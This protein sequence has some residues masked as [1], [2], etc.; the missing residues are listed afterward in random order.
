MAKKTVPVKYTDRD[1]ESIKQSLI[2]HAKRYYPET[3]KDFSEASFGSLMLDT[4]SYVGDVLSFYV[5][6]SV[7]ESFI[8]SAIEY[9][10][11]VKLA[12]QMGYR[13]SNRASSSG[14]LTFYIVAPANA[15]GTG[16][17]TNYLPIL[18]RGSEFSNNANALFML[19]EDVDFSHSSNEVVV[20]TVDDTTGQPTKYAVRAYGQAVS[21]ILVR[22]IVEIGAFESLR[23]IPLK[24]SNIVE[25]ISVLDSEGHEYFEVDY[26]TQDTIF[27]DVIYNSS[28]ANAPKY[29]LKAQSV[30]RRYVVENDGITTSIQFGYGDEGS[31]KDDAVADVSDV[32]LKV[33]GKN[34]ISSTMFDPT[35]LKSTDKLGVGPSNTTLQIV[36]RVNTAENANAGAR[37]VNNVVGPRFEFPVQGLVASKLSDVARNLEVTNEEHIVGEISKPTVSDIKL[38]AKGAYSAQNRAVTASDYINLVYRMPSNY[39]KIKRCNI[40]RDE[41]SLRRNLNLYVLSEDSNGKFVQTNSAVK[42]NLKVFL[43]Q[44][45]MLNDTVD[46]LDVKILNVG[47]E[48]EILSDLNVNKYSVLEKAKSEVIKYIEKTS[49]DVGEPLYISELIKALKNTT[50]V[51]DVLNINLVNKNGSKYSNLFWDLNKNKSK[52]GRLLF[53]PEDTIIE[54]KYPTTD[55]KGNIK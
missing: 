40:L 21:G 54:I 1:F 16:P 43:N 37:T 22:D 52:D 12:K 23:K 18:K 38:H 3:F 31:L 46:I 14:I 49:F 9:K 34:Y 19:N 39:G 11:V 44:Y 32:V 26:L 6:Y 8:D 10:N 53:V 45:K 35:N 5:D 51:I 27:R 7:N 55:I 13:F 50:G 48:F 33:H 17:D 2:E 4:V 30:P 25:V 42:Q 15:A 41:D 29:L 20:A 28:D 24:S 36:Y 47:V